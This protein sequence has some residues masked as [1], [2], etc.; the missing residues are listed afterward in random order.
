MLVHCK[1]MDMEYPN[2]HTVFQDKVIPQKYNEGI[3]IGK[4]SL[5]WLTTLQHVVMVFFI[6]YTQFTVS[7]NHDHSLEESEK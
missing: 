7:W 3:W 4:A 2:H 5:Q 1:G 6:L